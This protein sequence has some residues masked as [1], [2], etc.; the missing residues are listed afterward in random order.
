MPDP[1]DTLL[2]QVLTPGSSTIVGRHHF[3]AEEIIS[4][5]RKFDPQHFHV[6]PEAAKKSLL[7]GLCASGWHT[8]SVWMKLHRKSMEREKARL[9]EAGM[10]YPEFGPSPGMKNLRWVRPV[11][12][13][14]TVAFTETV[15]SLRQSNSKPEWTMKKRNSFNVTLAEIRCLKT[16]ETVSWTKVSIWE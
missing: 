13:N 4:F 14:E 2:P 1:L 12:E 8:V 7:G 5:A 11:Y 6:D 9:I 3:S 15:N 16:M 10:P